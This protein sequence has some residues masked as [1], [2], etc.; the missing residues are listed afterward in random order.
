MSSVA[1]RHACDVRWSCVGRSTA[2]LTE[3]LADGAPQAAGDVRP[4]RQAP[5][6]LIVLKRAAF[7]DATPAEGETRSGDSCGAGLIFLQS[8]V[9]EYFHVK[10]VVWRHPAN[11]DH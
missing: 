3:L 1:A 10:L 7:H 9:V 11:A 8:H 6:E 5:L 2:A 4:G